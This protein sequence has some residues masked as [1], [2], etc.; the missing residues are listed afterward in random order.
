M[1]VRIFALSPGW[2]GFAQWRFSLYLRALKYGLVD[3]ASML[4]FW[5][6]FWCWAVFVLCARPSMG[7]VQTVASAQE[8][9]VDSVFEQLSTDEKIAQLFVISAYTNRDSNHV[10]EVKFLI[11]R[12]QIGGLCFFQNSA[13]EQI[14]LCQEYQRLAKVP[15]MI[16]MDAEWGVGMRLDSVA[17]MPFQI[18]LG[19]MADA[20]Y[21]YEYG[22]IVA[23]QFKRIGAHFN[24]APVVDVNTNP[25]NP[26]INY[27]SFG[28]DKHTVAIM[29]AAYVR[30]LQD[31]G[32]LASLKHFPGHGDVS[33][34]S[35]FEL[36]YL[37]K[38]REQIGDELYPFRY[39]IEHTDVA[40]VMVAHLNLPKIMGRKKIPSSVSPEIVEQMLVKELNFRGLVFTD[41]LNMEAFRKY[42][43]DDSANLLALR[44]GNDILNIVDN[45]A[46]SVKTI[47]ESMQEDPGFRVQVYGK[48]KKI[49]RAKYRVGLS[50]RPVAPPEQ[51]LLFDLNE[52][53][54]TPLPR[55]IANN[56]ITLVRLEQPSVLKKLAQ[57]AKVLYV[58]V[59]EKQHNKF[60][61]LLRKRYNCD[62]RFVPLDMPKASVKNIY[63]S[64]KRHGDNVVVL[65]GL[66]RYGSSVKN[67][68][69]Y[70]ATVKFAVK[71]FSKFRH[72]I[73]VLFGNPYMIRNLDASGNILQCYNNEEYTQA[74]AADILASKQFPK[75][76]LP[77]SPDART[78]LHSGLTSYDLNITAAEQ[79]NA[80]WSQEIDKLLR[81]SLADGVFPGCS[82]LAL[83]K[84]KVIY[85]K[86][87][88]FLSTAGRQ[89]VDQHTIYD[90]AS[91]TKSLATTLAIMK[92]YEDG[93]IRLDDKIADHLPLLRTTNKRHITI[94]QALLHEAHLPAW[95]PYHRYLLGLKV[96]PSPFATQA[97]ATH[98]FEIANH[99]YMSTAWRDSL[100]KA[101]VSVPLLRERKYL[102]SDIGF[103]YLGWMIEKITGQTLEE[104]VR[105]NIFDRVG[106]MYTFFNPIHKTPL[107]RIAPTEQDSTFRHTLVHGYVHDYV[108]AMLGGQT[109]HAGLF[110]TAR[111]LALIGKLLSQG[112]RLQ[113]M[114]LFKPQTI[115]T[116]TK[117]GSDISRR[118]LGFDK[119][120]LA[121][122]PSYPSPLASEQSFGH[123]GFTGTMF[124][125][126]P[127][128]DL[129]YV[130][131][132]NCIH[133]S[134]S[135]TLLR[136]L[137]IREAVL[138]L[139]YQHIAAE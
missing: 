94:R 1:K 28:Q 106:T 67:N 118:S 131:L 17:V 111:D 40:G 97:S 130:F 12:Y 102:Y 98:P 4:Y 63:N 90:L 84:G 20:S 69:N 120:E 27:R 29:G 23:R 136:R 88:G 91:L 26:V 99:F 19:A 41:A 119:P 52:F 100:V 132:S 116:F 96:T 6:Y 138:H 39:C 117:Y 56:S 73:V 57:G 121:R 107:Y 16:F 61:Y 134:A 51:N 72:N 139:L 74:A 21:V 113:N 48:V 60:S 115:H 128:R 33:S 55:D 71:R 37:K 95:L 125:V 13:R 87:F 10:E 135:N 22:R 123:T 15:L 11:S 49:L 79:K 77:V 59:G 7:M 76:K 92:L 103:I 25:H 24:F 129:V 86:Q 70:N 126:D 110:G 133:P 68:Y 30:G 137:K 58:A 89:P 14:R 46:F 93:H 127:Q 65:V 109:G 9:W 114:Q 31:N 54:R 83:H 62:V 105:R 108:S 35:H 8:R 18:A 42:I 101:L 43:E 75:G 104:Y 124:W 78:P 38:N 53:E 81:R 50:R 36:P 85:E 82:V 5:K 80:D 64:Y 66:H 45:V 47:R 34:D 122:Q 112:G 3:N 44:A 2:F 32:V